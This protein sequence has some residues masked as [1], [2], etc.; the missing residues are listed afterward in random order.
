MNNTFFHRPSFTLQNINNNQLKLFR[1]MPQKDA[2]SD[3]GATFSGDRHHYQKTAS[4]VPPTGA[5]VAVSNRKMWYG[6]STNRMSSRVVDKRR[7]RAVGKTTMTPTP[8]LFGFTSHGGI[9]N[10]LTTKY[11]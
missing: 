1:G 8:V 4:S 6:N 9:K 2:T 5:S 11:Y 10:S 3:N 7:V